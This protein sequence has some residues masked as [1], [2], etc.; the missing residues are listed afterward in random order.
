[1]SSANKDTKN[2]EATNKEILLVVESL[3]NA[4][5][6]DKKAVFEALEAALAI[7]TRKRHNNTLDPEVHVD[8]HTGFY[9][10][11][12]CF[13]VVEDHEF[14]P[15]SASVDITLSQA[16]LENPEIKVGDIIRRPMES[17]EFG[18]IAAQ[19]ARQILAHKMREEERKQEVS[20]FA[21]KVGSLVTGVVKRI[22]RDGLFIDLG[23]T[24]A[25]L[26]REEMI[27]GESFRVGDRV[28][29]Y[30]Y[31]VHYEAKGPQ[32]FVTRTRP[33]MLIELFRIEV[34]EIGEQVIR[35]MSA[36]RDPGA[37]AKIAVKTNDGRIDPIGACVGVR[38]SR[39]Q[40]VSNELNGERI[41]IV[42]WDPN[43][44]QFVINAMSPAEV[45]SI[46]VDEDARV[47][48]VAVNREHLSQ[49][50]GRNG[51]NVKLAS[52]LTG[53]KLNVMSIEEAQ[54]RSVEQTQSYVQEFV[55][56]LN[57]DEEMAALLVQ[58]GFTSI[59][60]VA[61]VSEETLLE[62]PG[63]DSDLVEELR[64]R[65]RDYLLTKA[66]AGED[67]EGNGPAQDLLNMKGMTPELAHALV[68]KGI[69]TMEDLAELAVDDLLE[70]DGIDEKKAA[71]LIMTAREPWFK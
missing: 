13:T 60:E 52:D 69:K 44:A 18:R 10:T 3:S 64:S 56:G 2:K 16:K 14:T 48:E 40:A 47:I 9:E 35:V 55:D 28:R 23:N 63:F 42:L 19:A 54:Q 45:E 43:P 26:P 27:P 25:F 33:E 68:A 61:Y 49:A 70:I 67:S 34:P 7:A 6:I 4:K 65:A 20:K 1:M 50:I 51:Q 11:F 66:L 36:A 22:I 24:E 58:E 12:Q 41:D 30:L 37:R 59:E 53:W 31:Q 46:V 39:V 8:P 38:G 71:E 15:E 5:G 29:C 57:V 62:V 32:V 21:E 17:V